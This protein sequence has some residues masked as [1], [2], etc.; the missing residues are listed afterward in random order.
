MV[1][2][3]FIP[4]I[5]T[6]WTNIKTGTMVYSRYF[7]LV[8]AS[9]MCVKMAWS[10]KVT[11]NIPTQQQKYFSL[12]NDQISYLYQ[13]T[14]SYVM[15]SIIR[16]V[17]IWNLPRYD[18]CIA[19]LQFCSCILNV[20]FICTCISGIDENWRKEMRGFES[21]KVVNHLEIIWLILF[22]TKY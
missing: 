8:S 17:L 4:M 13:M 19:L 2:Y 5:R 12:I 1:Y 14:E 11:N 10:F 22:F 3:S 16:F 20:L 7:V 15:Y 21:V 18:N 9:S 6:A